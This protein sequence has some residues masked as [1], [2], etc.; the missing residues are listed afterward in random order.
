MQ[1]TVNGESRQANDGQTVHQLIQDL[2]LS[3]RAVA[4]EVNKK[5]VPRRTHD[6]ARLSDGDV[7]EVVTLVG[8]G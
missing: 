5:I 8:G 4:V 3:G 7:V 2:G 1:L 6:Q